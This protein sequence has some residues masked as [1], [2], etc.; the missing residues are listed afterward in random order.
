MDQRG[1]ARESLRRSAEQHEQ[2][3]VKLICCAVLLVVNIFYHAVAPLSLSL[4][5][6]LASSLERWHLSSA[7]Q[8]RQQHRGHLR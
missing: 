6:L 1:Q 3:F 8:A 4:S 7:Q 2:M 5:Y